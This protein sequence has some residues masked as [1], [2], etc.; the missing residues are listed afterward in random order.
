IAGS[1][2]VIAVN[3]W[4]NHP[5]GFTERA[6]V[7]T[8]IHPWQSLFA[9][10]FC[11]HALVHM[12][13]AAYMVV[14]FCVAAVYAWARLR[15]RADGYDRTALRLALTVAAVASVAHGGGGD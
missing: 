2:M 11:G 7:V 15:G 4:M 14:G 5:T 12:C 3:G 6:G 10:W 8:A 13:G 9:N 1:A